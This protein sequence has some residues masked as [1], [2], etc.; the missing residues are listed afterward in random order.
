MTASK[1][2]ECS[3]WCKVSAPSARASARRHRPVRTQ[4]RAEAS[5]CCLCSWRAKSNDRSARQ[6]RHCGG[7]STSARQTGQR[8]ADYTSLKKGTGPLHSRVLSPFSNVFQVKQDV[9]LLVGSRRDLVPLAIGQ[10]RTDALHQPLHLAA[11][12]GRNARQQALGLLEKRPRLHGFTLALARAGHQAR[13]PLLAALRFARISVLRLFLPELLEALA[14]SL[15]FVALVMS[16]GI[17]DGDLFLQARGPFPRRHLEH[18]VKIQV[19]LDGDLIACR[20]RGQAL[21]QETAD[22]VVVSDVLAFPLINV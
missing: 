15:L 6:R 3:S 16:Q 19:E 13:H 7:C 12:V 2:R 9:G 8:M 10:R 21:H 11:V 1:R 20:H 18:A 5:T 4:S 17:L 14:G 22:A